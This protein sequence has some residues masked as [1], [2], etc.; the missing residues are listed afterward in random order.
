MTWIKYQNRYIQT[1]HIDLIHVHETRRADNTIVKRKYVLEMDN[2]STQILNGA[3]GDYL[4]TVLNRTA[5]AVDTAYA[6]SNE[7]P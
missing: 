2:N 7:R 6:G 4:L 3:Q 5:G 1:D